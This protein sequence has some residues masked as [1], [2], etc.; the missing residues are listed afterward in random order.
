MSRA[1]RLEFPG[2]LW[3]V[4]SRGNER[5]DIVADDHDRRLLLDLLGEAAE[6]FRWIVYQYVLMTNHYHVVLQLE[7]ETLSAGMRWL[8]GRYAQAFNRRHGRVGH[9]FQGRFHAQF[10]EKETYLL[11]VLRYVV[12]NPVRAKMV[13]R[14]EDYEWS[15]HRATSG[16]CAP[17]KWLAVDRTLTCFAPVSG[18][19]RTLYMRFVD[20]GI[21]LERSPWRDTV[22]QIYLGS[23]AWVESMRDRIESKPRSDD[24]PVAQKDPVLPAMARV[25]AVV[26]DACSTSENLIRFGRGGAARMLAAWLGCRARLDLRSIAAGLRVRSGGGI[27]RLIYSCER[28]LSVDSELRAVADRC[29]AILRR[30]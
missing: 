23:D 30:V 13:V 10:V 25:I 22:A 17:P 11:E 2:S 15:G 3:H 18:I 19:A 12:L 20:D 28:Q 16:L 26:A 7:D 14:P 4:T 24:H 21:G 8:N 9:L 29:A 27:S 6:R 5:R 1:L